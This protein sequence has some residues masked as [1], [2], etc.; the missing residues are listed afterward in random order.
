MVF[1]LTYT[2]KILVEVRCF[3]NHA[4]WLAVFVLLRNLHFLVPLQ[5]HDFEEEKVLSTKHLYVRCV[6]K[7]V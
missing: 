4:F 2:T 1:V 6:C 3:H 7:C 5:K